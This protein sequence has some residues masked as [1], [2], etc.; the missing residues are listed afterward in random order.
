MHYSKPTKCYPHQS[1]LS[2][3]TL[4]GPFETAAL[5]AE[6]LAPAVL[7]VLYVSS[8][9]GILFYLAKTVSTNGWLHQSAFS[10]LRLSFDGRTLAS[11]D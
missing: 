2:F 4:R 11:D 8:P 1:A 10:S 9:F 3:Q 7:K 5:V 6:L